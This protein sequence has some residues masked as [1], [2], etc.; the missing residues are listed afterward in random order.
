MR[1]RK[2]I[3]DR[4]STPSGAVGGPATASGLNFQVD[5]TIRHA[6][7]AISQALADPITDLQISLEPRSVTTHRTLTCWDVRLSPPERVIEVKLKPRRADIEEWLDRVELGIRQ[8]ADRRF[9]LSY[10]RGAS[11]LLN[12]IEDLCRIAT[13]TNGNFHQFQDLIALE[14]NAA[15]DTVL[16]HLK[17]D[18]HMSLQRIRVTPIDA[19]SLKR[20]IHF[21]MRYLVSEPNRTRLYEFLA[22][23][24]H[25]GIEQRS[26]YHARDLIKEGTE[27]PVAFFAPQASLPP[28]LAPTVLSAVCILQHCET[29][30]PT[31]VLAAAILRSAQDVDGSLSKHTGV[32]GLSTDDGCWEIGAIE[33][34]LVH[35]NALH[36]VSTALRQLLEFIDRHQ[37]NV[38]GRQQVPNAIAL[39]KVCQSTEHELVSGLFWKLDKLLKR[40]GNKKLVLEVANISLATARRLPPT[41]TKTKGRAVALICGRAWV[42]QRIGR[43]REARADGEKSLRLGEDLEWWRNTAF[44]L[45]CLGRLFRMEAERHKAD[46]AQFK[47]L[48]ISSIKYLHQ[49]IKSFGCATELSEGDR[50][51]EVGDCHSLLGRTHLVGGDLV[52]ARAAARMAVERISERNSKDYAD[53]QILLG[54]LA[55][56]NGDRDGAVNLYDTAINV[57]GEE[58]AER[59]EIVARAYLQKGRARKSSAW[60]DQATEIWTRLEEDELADDARWQSMVLSGGV[61]ANTQRVLEEETA[62]VRVEMIRQHE[63]AL[64]KLSASLGQ[65]TE[66]DENYWRELAP[67]ARKSVAVRQS[68]W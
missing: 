57:A 56:A 2:S 40:T 58:D 19:Q 20:E 6:L 66:P 25:K 52:K 17:T 9:E 62:S 67:D 18:P 36:L 54:D 55:Y 23:K 49:A 11:P 44:C 47:E 7:E 63:D 50:K 26:T 14:Q 38:R 37:N 22:T 24:F 1:N 30:L 4:R 34:V 45:K 61:S 53:L 35:D 16:L 33:R 39:A 10:G 12:A 51:A 5:L 27:L 13:E 60:C 42:F 31:E 68:E 21:L 43:L 59:S 15:I 64:S 8:D 65:R 46:K 3:K 41:E 32:C 28:R 48:L 29:G